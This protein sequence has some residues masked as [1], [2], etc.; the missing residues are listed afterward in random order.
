MGFK[1]NKK[2]KTTVSKKIIKGLDRAAITYQNEVKQQL[3]GPRSKKKLGVVT[4][5]LRRSVQVDRSNINNGKVKIGSNLVYAPVHEL[6][7]ES[8]TARPY[9]MPALKKVKKNML[10]KFKNSL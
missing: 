6:G 2:L 9:F 3:S 5:S 8:I 4:G 7:Y 10:S 1:P